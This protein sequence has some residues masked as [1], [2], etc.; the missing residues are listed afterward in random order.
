MMKYEGI[1]NLRGLGQI[2]NAT[3]ARIALK[4]PVIVDISVDDQHVNHLVFDGMGSRKWHYWLEKRDSGPHQILIEVSR[5]WNPRKLG[6]SVDNRDLGV[7]VGE[8]EFPT[9]F[10]VEGIGFYDWETWRGD[11]IPGW[12]EDERKFRWMGAQAFIPIDLPSRIAYI[13]KYQ[14]SDEEAHRKNGLQVFLKSVHP[15]VGDDPVV[16]EIY[17]D[18]MLLKKIVLKGKQW[19]KIV[20]DQNEIKDSK[21]LGIKVSRTWNPRLLGVSEDGRDLGVAVVYKYGVVDTN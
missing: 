16:V 5:T 1:L 3:G 11:A 21:V 19:E 6:I 8:P 13:R 18:K 12:T 15:D 9:L 4:E 20:F 10:P 7:A 2:G 17:R 14:P